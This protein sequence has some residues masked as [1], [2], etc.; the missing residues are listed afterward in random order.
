MEEHRHGRN[1]FIRYIEGM[2]RVYHENQQKVRVLG[3]GT[4]PGC[5]SHRL[6]SDG[7]P[8]H[9]RKYPVRHDM[10]HLGK[11]G[12]YILY[13]TM[14]DAVLA[15]Y[16]D[17]GTCNLIVM[18]CSICSIWSYG[19]AE[20]SR[21]GTTMSLGSAEGSHRGTLGSMGLSSGAM[22]RGEIEY[23]GRDGKRDATRRVL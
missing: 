3:R 2:P 23:E 15:K 18:S 6:N 12:I 20:V 21:P 7:I 13:F 8:L 10:L 17:K 4:H 9:C 19:G 1:G 14:S 22:G 16:E 11:I 5:L